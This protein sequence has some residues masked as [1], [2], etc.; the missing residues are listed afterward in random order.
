[1]SPDQLAKMQAGRQAASEARRTEQARLDGDEHA[2]WLERHT[3]A[4]A[5]HR[6]RWA[7]K[8]AAWAAEAS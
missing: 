3:R 2:A 5:E 6:V 1:M 8:L 7:A 4:L